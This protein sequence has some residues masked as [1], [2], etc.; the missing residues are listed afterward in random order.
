[1]GCIFGTV[2]VKYDISY[3]C[4]YPDIFCEKLIRMKIMMMIMMVIIIMMMMTESEATR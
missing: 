2:F 4:L 3:I 1:M